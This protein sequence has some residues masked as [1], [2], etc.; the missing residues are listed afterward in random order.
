MPS[1]RSTASAE[2][3]LQKLAP[4]SD[5]ASATVATP[6]FPQLFAREVTRAQRYAVFR[7]VVVHRVFAEH[8]HHLTRQAVE[9]HSAV[10]RFSEFSKV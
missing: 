5:S 3:S 8:E 2:L 9:F 4:I 6:S 10:Q 7:L 1:R